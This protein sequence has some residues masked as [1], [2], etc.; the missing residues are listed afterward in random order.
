MNR[1]ISNIF[2]ALTITLGF[3]QLTT[4]GEPAPTSYAEGLIRA[5]AEMMKSQA[6]FM[7][8]QASMLTARAQAQK[9][10]CEALKLRYEAQAMAMNNQ[11]KRVD[12]YFTKK[13]MRRAYLAAKKA[14]RKSPHI[15]SKSSADELAVANR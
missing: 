14:Q 9:A 11:I 15:P 12:T 8:A 1:C 5:R 2:F 4:A 10:Y 13:E 7:K 3:A 6:E